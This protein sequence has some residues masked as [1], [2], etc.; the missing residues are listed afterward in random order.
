MNLKTRN[1]NNNSETHPFYTAWEKNA[2][3]LQILGF[4]WN[5]AEAKVQQVYFMKKKSIQT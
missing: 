2:L 3:W 1:R 4:V 5:I